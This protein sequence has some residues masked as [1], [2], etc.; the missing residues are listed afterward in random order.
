[1]AYHLERLSRGSV[2]SRTDVFGNDLDEA[3]E[4]TTDALTKDKVEFARL[5]EDGSGNSGPGEG[6]I[7]AIY[8]AA[9]GWHKLEA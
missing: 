1:M 4:T 7:V 5:M 6:R 9:E 2:D 8:T 3:L